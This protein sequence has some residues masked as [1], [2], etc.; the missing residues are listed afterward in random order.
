MGITAFND[1]LVEVT[2]NHQ[3]CNAAR[4]GAYIRGLLHGAKAQERGFTTRV[5][6]KADV[7]VRVGLTT[8]IEVAAAQLKHKLEKPWKQP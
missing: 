4:Y 5:R 7:A 1:D 6:L 2:I 3:R 8:S